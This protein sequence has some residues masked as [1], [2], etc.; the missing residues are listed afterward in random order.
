M[1]RLVVQRLAGRRGDLRGRLRPSQGAADVGAWV[2]AA[3]TILYVFIGG[4]LAVAWTDFI[5]MI[6]LVLGLSVIAFFSEELGG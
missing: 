6:V 2:G 3:A 4:F 1:L 5:Q